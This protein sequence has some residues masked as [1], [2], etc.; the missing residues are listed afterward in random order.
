MSYIQMPGDFNRFKT[1][2]PIFVNK[3]IPLLEQ[4][5]KLV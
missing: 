2:K 3:N 5:K 4:N 1:N